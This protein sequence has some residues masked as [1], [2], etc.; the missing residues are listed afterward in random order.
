MYKHTYM[1]QDGLE[2]K[3]I[4][5]KLMKR[6][7]SIHKKFWLLK[8]ASHFSRLRANEALRLNSVVTTF[9][10]LIVI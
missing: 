2:W 6:T 8:T 4:P 7:F 5:S 3:P 1:M 10:L 9:S